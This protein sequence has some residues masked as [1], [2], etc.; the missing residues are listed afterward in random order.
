[1]LALLCGRMRAPHYEIGSTAKVLAKCKLKYYRIL[2]C[3]R[4]L[5]FVWLPRQLK[6][7]CKELEPGEH[8]CVPS[9]F[10]WNAV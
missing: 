7:L 1:M 10:C 5:G 6:C 4:F 8:A 3:T 2:E 9:M